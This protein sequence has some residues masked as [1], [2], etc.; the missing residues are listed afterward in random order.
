MVPVQRTG[1]ACPREHGRIGSSSPLTS[2]LLTFWS[3]WSTRLM[4]AHERQLSN[5][6][7]QGSQPPRCW[8][9]S[10]TAPLMRSLPRTRRAQ[11]P[12]A[13]HR[14]LPGIGKPPEDVL[15]QTTGRSFRP[16]RPTSSWRRSIGGSGDPASPETNERRGAA[17]PGGAKASWPPRPLLTPKEGLRYWISCDISERRLRWRCTTTGNACA[18]LG[19]HAP[20][21]LAMFDREMRYRGEP[22][23]AG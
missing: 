15:G 12:A 13:Q 18:C 3:G 7:K 21:A 2:V 10:P 11:R 20:A 4:A 6:A 5:C 19:S 22:P 14:G 17:H 9:Q 8:W 23:L 16:S 1:D